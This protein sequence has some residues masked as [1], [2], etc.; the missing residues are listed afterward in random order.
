MNP[1][2]ALVI[3]FAVALLELRLLDFAAHHG[4]INPT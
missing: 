1:F 2:L 4:W 3:T